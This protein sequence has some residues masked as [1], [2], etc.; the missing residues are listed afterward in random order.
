[1]F[2]LTTSAPEITEKNLFYEHLIW[3]ISNMYLHESN[4]T[5]LMVFWN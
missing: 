4:N 5:F 3:L 2:P 1:M